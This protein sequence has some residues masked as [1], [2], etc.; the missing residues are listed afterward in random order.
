MN[1]GDAPHP[2]EHPHYYDQPTRWF[3][4]VARIKRYRDKRRAKKKQESASDR[5]ARRTAIATVWIAIFTAATIGVGIS[6]FF[7]LR[8]QLTAMNG[9]LAEMHSSGVDTHNLVAATQ[10]LADHAKDQA[11]AM[12][13]LRKAGE[14]QA[15]AM[16][17][18]SI[19][20]EAQAR[21]MDKLKAA[22]EAQASA[23][24][25]LAQAGRTQADATRNLADNSARQLG[26]IQ[27]SADAAKAQ[28]QAVRQQ[29]DATVIASKATDRL[30][31]AGQAQANAV[32]Q[33][34]DV[35]RAAN[36]IAAR[37]S[38]AADRPWVSIS[39]PGDVEPVAGQDYKVDVGLSNV[40]RSPAINI[41]ARVDMTI[42]PITA[43]FAFLDKCA[44]NCQPFTIFPTSSAFQTASIVYHPSLAASI[45]TAEEIKRI[46]DRADAILLRV[47]VDYQDE[48]GNTHIT[49]DCNAL[50]PKLGF[51]SCNGGNE[52]N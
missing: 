51:T 13:K 15:T 22:G 40:G 44:Q 35:A 34:L 43:T 31:N 39:M 8:G 2:G 47:R 23:T 30:A 17:N 21:S 24:E 16:N 48:A 29:A 7:I 36:D 1:N 12:D 20:G 32:L 6:Q 49:T 45:F 10:H 18:L 37:A 46:A 9:Q 50:V 11:D 27:A 5:A 42:I 41:T 19:A 52:A 26:A 38:L 4:F 14:S 25:N 3:R 33:S 28:A